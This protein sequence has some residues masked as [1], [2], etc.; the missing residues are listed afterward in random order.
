MLASEYRKWMSRACLNVE[1]SLGTEMGTPSQS[2]LTEDY[3]RVALLRG[4]AL[5]FPLGAD[6]IDRES[7]VS[8]TD[9][10]CI[11]GHP[12]PNQGRPLQHDVGVTAEANSP[13]DAG[14]VLELKWVEKAETGLVAQDIWKLALS[15]STLPEGGA[16][17]GY[18]VIGGTMDG[19]SGTL[20]GLRNIGMDLRWSPAGRGKNWP[21]PSTIDLGRAIKSSVGAE[22][23]R[24]LISKGKHYRSP[25][26]CWSKLRASL[27]HR[28]MRGTDDFRSASGVKWRYLVWELDHRTLGATEINWND[29]LARMSL[30]CQ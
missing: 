6:R 20:T 14:L 15:R 22:A 1:G 24:K 11:G 17:R 23:F 8:W 7:R 30:A 5:S 16:V 3:I 18:L 10:D 19:V 21:S 25:P 9:Q 28:W 13:D 27:R 29:E 12:I 26:A 4:L 2:V